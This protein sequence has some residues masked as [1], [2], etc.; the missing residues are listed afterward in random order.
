MV[1]L[2]EQ[3][4]R[5]DEPRVIVTEPRKAEPTPLRNPLIQPVSVLTKEHVCHLDA[6]VPFAKSGRDLLVD[7]LDPVGPT[8]ALRDT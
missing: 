3:L 8:I 7:G 1:L 2:N 4:Q 6:G 5:V